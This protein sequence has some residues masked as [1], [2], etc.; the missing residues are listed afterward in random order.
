MIRFLINVYIL[1]LIIDAVVSYAPDL[2]RYPAVQW[3]NKIANYSLKHVR[4]Y[5][6]SDLPFDPSPLVVIL[7]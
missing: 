7:A 2:K 6:P 4:K 3:I 5:M 1:I